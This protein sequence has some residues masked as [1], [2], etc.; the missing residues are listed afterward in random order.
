MKTTWSFD[1]GKASIGEAVRDTSNHSFPHL[2]SLLI[3]QDFAETKT[4]ATR[5]RMKRTREAHKAR[6]AWLDAVWRAAGLTPLVGRRVE[7]RE[8][9]KG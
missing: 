5:R 3:P 4:A 9:A 2:E 8:D 7:E 1:L 6:E